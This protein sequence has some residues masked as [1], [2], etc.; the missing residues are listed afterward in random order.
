MD[1]TTVDI[2]E[3]LDINLNHKFGHNEVG[4]WFDA[5]ILKRG[6]DT[7]D[8][9]SYFTESLSSCYLDSHHK[10]T[11]QSCKAIAYQ[12]SWTVSNSEVMALFNDLESKENK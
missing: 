2:K 5:Y 3:Y 6:G 7:S 11:R 4:A 12:I 10:F 1:I 8:S 9:H